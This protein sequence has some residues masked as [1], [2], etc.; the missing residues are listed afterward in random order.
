MKTLILAAAFILAVSFAGTAIASDGEA[1]F[2]S[3]G[4]TACHGADGKGTAMAPGLAGSDFVKGNPCA[5]KDTIKNGREGGAKKFANFPLSMPKN[6]LSDADLD[7]V[8]GYLKG[9]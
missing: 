2:K 5:V 3:K 1:V 7:A 6:A 4:C 8:V 9:L